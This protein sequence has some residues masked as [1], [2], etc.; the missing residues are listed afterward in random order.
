MKLHISITAFIATAILSISCADLSH[1]EGRLDSLESRIKAIEIVLPSLNQNIE[2]LQ[3]MTGG[4]VINKVELVSGKYKITLSNSEVLYLTQGSIGIANPPLLSINA[5]GYWMIDYQDGYGFNPVLRDGEKVKAI[6]E[7]AK[8]PTMGVDSDGYWTVSYDNGV[9]TTQVKDVNGKPVSALPSESADE[10]FSKVELTEDLFSITMKDGSEIKIPVL[11]DFMY[12]IESTSSIEIFKPN[13]TKVFKI[14]SSGTASATIISIPDGFVATV[15]KEELTVKAS[16]LTKVSADSRTDLSILAISERGYA[17]IAKI[18]VALE[19]S[20]I[21]DLP[22]EPVEP[23]NPV[24]PEVPTDRGLYSLYQTGNDIQIGDMVIN[25]AVYGDASLIDDAST[26]KIIESAGVYFIEPG[27]TGVSIKSDAQKLI[28][29]SNGDNRATI[30]RNGQT[31]MSATTLD[32][33]H[34]IMS[35]IEYI[36]TLTKG[37]VFGAKGEGKFETILLHGCKIEIPQNMNMMYSPIQILNFSIIDCDI[38]LN[39]G[40]SE[41]NILQS[42]TKEAYESV[43]FKNNIVYCSD[44]SITGF[45]FMTHT[46]ATI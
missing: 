15:A 35:N 29:I 43:V 7:N 40:E 31:A 21:P 41:N 14:T 12:K 39:S 5:E 11:S 25:K 3:M 33:D 10:Y 30:T 32:D 42:N 28:I 1:I 13:Q 27:T 19:N 4:I 17:T 44:E 34:F 36:T 46:N 20:D 37:N 8:T 18:Q 9:T 6:G 2:V 38:R 24:E 16:A 26:N 22:S 45:R 23:E